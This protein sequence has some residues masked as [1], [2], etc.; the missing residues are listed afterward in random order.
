MHILFHMP[1]H[2]VKQSVRK[3]ISNIRTFISLEGDL[4]KKLNYNYWIK[5]GVV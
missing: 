3:I 4:P 5:N 1:H 2:V